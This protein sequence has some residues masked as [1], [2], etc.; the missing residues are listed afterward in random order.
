MPANDEETVTF[1]TTRTEDHL[2]V[3]TTAR[4]VP[5]HRKK[6]RPWE[7]P[8]LVR[9]G[10]AKSDVPPSETQLVKD[11]YQA[12]GLQEEELAG[13]PYSLLSAATHGRFRQ[14]EL[15][16]YASTG[17]SLGGRAGARRTC[18][19]SEAAEPENPEE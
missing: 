10:Q 1:R 19:I 11:L 17:P 5:G 4:L 12:S 6:P 13:L 18:D 8:F 15:V 16:G 3:G 14:V 7:A 9:E 2:T